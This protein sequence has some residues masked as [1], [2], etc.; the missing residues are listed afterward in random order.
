MLAES[1]SYV[2]IEV[3][4]TFTTPGDGK[5]DSWVSFIPSHNFMHLLSKK[6][7]SS[8]NN[9]KVSDDS[10]NY[11]IRAYFESLSGWNAGAKKTDLSTS[12]FDRLSTKRSAI[13]QNF[14]AKDW[15]SA[16]FWLGG[17]LHHDLAFQEKAFP[18]R[19]NSSLNWF[20]FPQSF[21]S[22]MQA[23][24]TRVSKWKKQNERERE[25]ASEGK[26]KRDE[27]KT[28]NIRI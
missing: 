13:M 8:I 1:E 3:T 25:S 21:S 17:V 20:P 22:T 10:T 5:L 24:I 18:E 28:E 7:N 4:P 6:V 19:P 16:E 23:V 12:I 27:N 2:K 14:I 26:K 11:A 9:C 15:K